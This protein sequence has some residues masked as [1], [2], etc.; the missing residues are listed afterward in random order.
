MKEKTKQYVSLN[1]QA[2]AVFLPL[3]TSFVENAAVGLGLD[4]AEAL[5]LTLATEEIFSYLCQMALPDQAIEIR[6]SSGGYYIR[7]D[8]HFSVEDFNMRA[9]NLTATV[10]VDDEAAWK[11]WGS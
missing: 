5:S 10:S 8:F 1:V 9:F 2:D 4:H 3:A 6:C 7:A 11:R